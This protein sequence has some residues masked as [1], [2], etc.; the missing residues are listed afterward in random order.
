MTH[1]QPTAPEL[2]GMDA[3]KAALLKR[4]PGERSIAWLARQLDRSR[5]AVLQW[6]K[7]PEEFLGR[8]CELTG[9]PPRVVRPDLAKMFAE[10]ANG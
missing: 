1:D 4:G 3:V 7:V 10:E 9:L 5:G 6:G 2:T 8:V